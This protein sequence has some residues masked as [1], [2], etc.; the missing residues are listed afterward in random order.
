MKKTNV[1]K[2]KVIEL[3][4]NDITLDDFKHEAKPEKPSQAT[5]KITENTFSV[6]FHFGNCFILIL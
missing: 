1:H 3:K 5:M 2:D 4:N 6:S